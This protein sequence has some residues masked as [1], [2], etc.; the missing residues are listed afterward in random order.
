MSTKAWTHS[1]ALCLVCFGCFS[2]SSDRPPSGPNF[3]IIMADDLGYGDSSVFN[4]WIETP[5]L[6]RMARGGMRFTDFH[7]SGTVCSPTRAGLLTGRY[8]QRTGISRAIQRDPDSR[9]SYLGLQTSEVTFAELLGDKG[10][11]TAIVGKWHLG[12]DRKYNPI[13]HGFDQFRGFIGG[14][15]D[16]ISHYD[17]EET[18]D[19]WD[20]LEQV[21]EVGYTT[22]LL[23]QHAISF[24]EK[25]RDRPFVLYLSHAA[26]HSPIQAPGDAAVRGPGRDPERNRGRSQETAIRGMVRALDDNV[27]TILDT[28]Q[29]LELD[30]RTLVFFFS[31]N[32]GASHMRNEPLRGDKGTAFEGGHRVPAIAW[33]PGKIEPGIE[34]DSLTISLDLMPTMLQLAEVALPAGHHVDGRS[35]APVLFDGQRITDRKLFWNGRAMRD[36]RWKLLLQKK[37]PLLF[38]LANDLPESTDLSE[39]YPERIESMLKDIEAWKRDVNSSATPQPDLLAWEERGAS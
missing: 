2:S 21:E 31:D 38:D 27:G 1:L 25:N 36:G 3:V 37:K 11:A 4:G 26:V 20:G 9:Q 23:T 39:R 19:W 5:Q 10:Y 12:N 33:W 15:I 29:R 13:H 32:G 30:E 6:A 17:S 7:S 8:Q 28:L 34:N 24:L 22:H 14:N 18:H 35:L 16:Y